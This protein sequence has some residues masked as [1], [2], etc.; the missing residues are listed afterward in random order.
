[1]GELN[2]PSELEDAESG[3]TF[4]ITSDDGGEIDT[5]TA[6]YWKP[7]DGGSQLKW[8]VGLVEV[9]AEDSGYVVTMVTNDQWK[10]DVVDISPA[11]D[12]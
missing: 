2:E 11:D 7:T 1:M 10:F 12:E 6:D 5:L 4:T 3:E 8:D 9:V